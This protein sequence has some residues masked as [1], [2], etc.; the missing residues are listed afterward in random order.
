MTGNTAVTTWVDECIK[1]CKPDKVHWCDGSDAER[2]MLTKMLLDRGEFQRL[3]EKNWPNCFLYRSD[4]TD[5]ARTEKVTYICSEKESDCGPTNNYLS[6]AD[7]EAQIRPRY[8]GCMKGRTMY[9]LPYVMGPL[10][11]P[12]SKVGFQLTDSVY[13]V[14]NMF[15]MA[16]VGKKALDQLGNSTDFVKGMHS[17]GELKP[18]TRA[19]CH[20]PERNEIWS[21][22]SGYGG[23]A[24]LGKKC[25]ALRI[26]SAQARREGWLAEH[27][28]ILG[29][30]NPQGKI[31]YIAA[32]FPSAC[33]K[34]NLAMVIPPNALKGWKAWTV[35]DDIAWMRFGKDGRLY[36]IN[37]E[38]G[39]FGVAPGTSAKTNLNALK[40]AS[41]NSLFT[42][43]GVD[44][45]GNVWWEGLGPA[46][47]KLTDWKGNPWTPDSPEKAAHPNSRFTTP[48]SQCPSISPKWED[49]EGVPISAILF[50]GRRAKLVP[51]V[52]E[53]TSWDNGVLI[54]ASMGSE[55]TAAAT[56]TKAGTI[57]HDPMAMLP[58]CGYHMGDYF[59]HWID[60][61][62]KVPNPPKIYGVN[63][64]RQD[65]NGKFLWP[66][67]GDNVRV[68]QWIIDRVEGKAGAVE[69]PLGNMPR[70]D[71][72]NR[73]GLDCSEV[74]LNTILTVDKP[75]WK[76]SFDETR[77]YFSI[78][79]DRF[80]KALNAEMEALEKRLS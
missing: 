56:D 25:H 68:L 53:S 70:P 19:I 52:V 20:F 7:A 14:L 74:A 48:A 41:A 32:A 49:P 35:G 45:D 31:Y 59:Q 4:P 47:A 17:I 30:E 55:A 18:E 39:F 22:G 2:D 58:F 73:E 6:P 65:E 62:K 26:A 66:G 60:M 43:V 71:D 78:F 50:G 9:V 40:T 11:S 37:P 16:R 36:A 23:N 28:L 24:L 44:D 21:F 67:F 8:D 29:L 63:W 38:A 69:T 72:L 12:Y 27:M 75:A 57:R 13:V 1:L 76:A 61:G 3:N 42:N 79:G 80:P 51:L 10:G 34:T 54:G 46:P 15:I 64:F 5:V 77:E 33:G